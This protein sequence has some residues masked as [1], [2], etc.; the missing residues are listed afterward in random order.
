MLILLTHEA[1]VFSLRLFLELFVLLFGWLVPIPYSL[2][3]DREWNLLFVSCKCGSFYSD[4]QYVM[5]LWAFLS[6]HQMNEQLRSLSVEPH[7]GS[8]VVR[9]DPLRF[10]AGCCKKRL[11]LALS[12][13][14]LSLGFLWFRVPPG[15]GKSQKVMEF[16]KTIF[17]AWKVMENGKVSK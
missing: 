7:A 10:L 16:R 17:Q 12:V 13:L 8:G 5:S 11:N 1:R 2:Q 14:S 6:L 9:I 4:K 3:L 15:H